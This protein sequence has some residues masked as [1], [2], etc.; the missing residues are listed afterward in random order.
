MDADGDDFKVAP[1][2]MHKSYEI[3]YRSLS[4]G[5]VEKQ[6]REDVEYICNI[7]GVEVSYDGPL[8]RA[9][10]ACADDVSRREAPPPSF[11]DICR[12]TR[13]A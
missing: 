1:K 8:F 9:L 6:M 13:S 11:C 12:G 3:D 4:Q 7:L 2:T 10:Y 5:D